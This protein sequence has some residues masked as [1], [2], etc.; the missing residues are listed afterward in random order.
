[1]P[2]ILLLN[3]AGLNMCSIFFSLIYIDIYE[4]ETKLFAFKQIMCFNV[5][6]Y[7]EIQG[8]RMYALEATF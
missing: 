6:Y 7:W 8:K 3:P 2:L 1:M 4:Q 5:F